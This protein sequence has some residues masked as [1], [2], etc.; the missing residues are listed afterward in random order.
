M[1][2]TCDWFRPC[3]RARRNLEHSTGDSTERDF[4]A[5]PVT[6]DPPNMRVC[7]SRLPVECARQESNVRP[8]G[9]VTWPEATVAR[10]S[11]AIA[12]A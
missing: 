10:C 1:S 3:F 9:H 5:S 8:R 6:P 12:S 4:A 2:R 7:V 11:A